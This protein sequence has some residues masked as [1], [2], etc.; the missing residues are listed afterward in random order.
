LSCQ[1]YRHHNQTWP[2]STRFSEP[3][4]L[5]LAALTLIMRG[6]RNWLPAW[7]HKYRSDSDGLERVARRPREHR[8]RDARSSGLR[9]YV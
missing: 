4:G 6:R 2:Q 1:E 7:S 3:D 5:R 8:T 9:T